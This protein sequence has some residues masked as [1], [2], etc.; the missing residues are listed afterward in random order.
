MHDYAGHPFQAQLSRAMA[1][2]GHTVRH[3]YNSSNPTSPKG[4][5]AK[6]PSDSDRLEFESIS[7]PRDILKSSFF[8]RWKLERLYGKLLTKQVAE[9]SPNVVI[10]ANTPLDAL[11]SLSDACERENI[12][13]VFWLQDLIGKASEQI[14]RKKLP[15]IGPQI[16]K[17]YIRL[18]NTLLKKSHRV[19]G[20]SEEFRAEVQRANVPMERYLTIPNWAP[21][22]EI[23]PTSKRNRWAIDRGLEE[24]FVYLY[25]GTLGFKH[26]PILFLKLA[27]SLLS[28]N[29]CCVV[30][31]SEGP[32]ADWL[33]DKASAEGLVNLIVNPFQPYS[34]MSDV[35][36]TADV[37]ISILESSA[38][39]F[40][41]PS[42]VLSYHCA[43]RPMLLAVPSTNLASRIVCQE[44]T[45][46]VVDP[47]NLDE[48]VQAA[49][50][51]R[52]LPSERIAMSERA[53]AYAEKTF[54]I[55][56]ISEKFC[57]IISCSGNSVKP[58]VMIPPL[59][60]ANNLLSP[61]QP[62]ERSFGVLA[63]ESGTLT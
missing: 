61:G 54:N 3:V 6:L 62:A 55:D 20:I 56:T 2:H 15:L 24:R 5:L 63:R 41:I 4:S 18:E 37:L 50:R 13:W 39:A 7:L 36:G 30:V 48:F 14:L 27:Q 52:A 22:D 31:N 29:S 9:F 21:L 42:K 28:D 26:N 44:R 1:K 51:L 40:S 45:G 35:L 43:A 16:G 19:V 23:I 59:D 46:L 32:A 11:K 12:P 60:L 53:R 25:S 33:R 58:V 47:S 34:D 49:I 10:S 8:D 57:E 17:H 38:G